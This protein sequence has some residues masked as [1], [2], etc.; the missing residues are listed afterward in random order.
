[1]LCLLPLQVEPACGASLAPFYSKLP[2]VSALKG[3]R[4]VIIVCGGCA[5]SFEQ[6][7]KWK[8]QFEI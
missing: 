4:I 7:L 6:L 1:M 2:A 3:K 5:I 8:E